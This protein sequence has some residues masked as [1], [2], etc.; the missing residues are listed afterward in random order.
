[1]NHTHLEACPSTQ[2][3]LK[4]NL[5]ALRLEQQDD[6]I[7]V[8]T[9]KQTAGLGRSNHSWTHYDEALAFSCT[10]KMNEFKAV[11]SL[12]L[13][14]ALVRYFK[15]NFAVELNLKWP[16]DL[17]NQNLQKCA[18]LLCHSVGE[19]LIAGLGLNWNSAPENSFNAG[20]IFENSPLEDEDKK[21]FPQKIYERLLAELKNQENI[22]EEWNKACCHLNQEVTWKNGEE[23]FRGIFKGIKTDG[24][25]LIG[26]REFH[27]GSLFMNREELIQQ[28]H[29][30]RDE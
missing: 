14:V 29:E 6:R 7:L 20:A 30:V 13:G 9:K 19:T 3:F 2:I 26:E 4:E 24:S 21:I 27:S 23:E 1:M 10:F 18:G 25:A 28:S 5:S 16:N 22:I 15:K 12:F 11:P 17:Y 8:S